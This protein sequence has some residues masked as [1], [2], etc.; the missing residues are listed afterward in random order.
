MA[1][2]FNRD[3]S[4]FAG[5]AQHT[6]QEPTWEDYNKLTDEE[7]KK[8]L[9]DGLYFYSYYCDFDDLKKDFKAYALK[10]FK[11]EDVKFVLRWHKKAAKTLFTSAK[12]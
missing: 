4:F 3:G 7:K 5:D 9:H 1:K 2:K 6:G 8:R 11:P 10:H 12:F